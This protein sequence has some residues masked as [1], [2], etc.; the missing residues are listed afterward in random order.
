MHEDEF[1]AHVRERA[2]LE[3]TDEA[4]GATEAALRV[5]GTRLT[6]PEAE[7]LAA[8]LPEDFG[9]ALTWQSGTEPK[10]FDADAF[11]DRVGDRGADDN[12]VDSSDAEAHAKA[13]MS[14]LADAVS[15]GEIA[16]IRAQLPGGYER[17]FDPT[18]ATS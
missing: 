14:V 5:L 10:A 13:V 11:V 17:L 12:R 8:Q 4:R 9:A 2:D 7:D 1:L 3:S 18:E 6:E 16:D 15:A